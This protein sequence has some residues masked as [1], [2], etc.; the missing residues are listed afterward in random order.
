MSR[1]FVALERFLERLVERPAARLFRAPLQPVQLQRRLE[2]A[3]ETERRVGAQRTWA[4]NRYRV[5]LHP[6]D[7]AQFSG[8]Q[9]TLEV[10]LAEG[11]LERAHARGY[12]LVVRP[13]VT[14]HANNGVARGDVAVIAVLDER[15][16]GA[17]AGSRADG[18]A[19][20]D[21]G[22]DGPAAGAAPEHTAVFTVPPVTA[23]PLRLVIEEPGRAARRLVVPQAGLRIG[24]GTDNDLVLADGRVSRHHGRLVPRRGA[25]VYSD[26]GSTNGSFLHGVRVTEIVLGPGDLLRLGETRLTIEAGG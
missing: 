5:Q 24:R 15:G 4:P 22:S 6:D 21:D 1:P 3:M 11:L 10:E 16:Q 14:L 12:A 19:V 7:L 9:A 17:P 2:R 26:I 20:V 13:R 8:Y 23:P 18:A 25:W